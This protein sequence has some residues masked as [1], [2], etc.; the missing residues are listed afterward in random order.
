VNGKKR[1]ETDNNK[2]HAQDTHD[3]I[4][5]IIDQ[6]KQRSKDKQLLLLY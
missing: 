4:R 5:Q 2:Q 3:K 1:H 6:S